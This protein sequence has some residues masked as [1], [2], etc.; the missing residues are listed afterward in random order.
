MLEGSAAPAFA[1][2]QPRIPAKSHLLSP[3]S[4]MKIKEDVECYLITIG[5][6]NLGSKE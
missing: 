4:C 2:F 3:E 1:N 5:C 6:D